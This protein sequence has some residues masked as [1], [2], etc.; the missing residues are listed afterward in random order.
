[1]QKIK[2][3]LL[4]LYGILGIAGWYGFIHQQS[5]THVTYDNFSPSHTVSYVRSVVW[6][7]SRGKLQELRSILLNEDLKKEERIKRRIEN[8]LK[9]RTSAY[10]REFNGLATP[11]P[12]LG[13]WY[14]SNFDFENL[15]DDV[16]DIVFQES[17]PVDTK[18][19]DVSDVM[20]QYQNQTTAKLI[21]QLNNEEEI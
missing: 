6:Y 4:A 20:E 19:G 5:A 14:A 9:H 11:V 15:L 13:D 3:I 2:Y 16:F 10:I 12:N 17:T 18:I 1:M 21:N 7:H 8:M